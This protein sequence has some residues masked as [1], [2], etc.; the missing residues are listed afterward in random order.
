MLLLLKRIKTHL[1]GISGAELKQRELVTPHRNPEFNTIH[2]HI[3]LERHYDFLG[4]V[5]EL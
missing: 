1:L 3:R 2:F 5:S 4:K